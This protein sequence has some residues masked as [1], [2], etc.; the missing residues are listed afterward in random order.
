M[1]IHSNFRENFPGPPVSDRSP[2]EW[3]LT[4]GDPNA[5]DCEFFSD[6]SP[7]EWELTGGDPNAMDCEFL[8]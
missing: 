8:P 1:I 2:M 7:M 5:M 4:G 6:P 3:E